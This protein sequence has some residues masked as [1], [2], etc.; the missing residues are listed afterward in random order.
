MR[1]YTTLPTHDPRDTARAFRELEDIGYD[2]AFS[3]ESKHDPFF[4]L[5]LAAGLTQ[6]LE[7]GTAVAI[8]F[9]RAQNKE[10]LDRSPAGAVLSE[11]GVK[12]LAAA[13][14]TSMCKALTGT[15]PL[16]RR[17]CA[18]RSPARGPTEAIAWDPC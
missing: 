14:R 6:R 13:P 10:V 3:F 4:P 15:R 12:P 17:S 11:P 8:G 1:I 5:A 16:R 7:L 18:R 2:G 9:A